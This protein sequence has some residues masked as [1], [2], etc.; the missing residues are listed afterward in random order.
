MFT[1]GNLARALGQPAPA[2]F[3]ELA[4]CYGQ[5]TRHYHNREH[6]ADCLAEFAT[7]RD[8]AQ[9]P[10]EVELAI[11]FHDAVYDSQ[12]SD[13]E[14]KSAEFAVARL[15]ALG[16][17]AVAWERIASIILAT[18]THAGL[19]AIDEKLMVDA[20]LAILAADSAK[21]AAYDAAIRREYAWVPEERYRPAR[22]AVLQNF[23]ARAYI[24]HT[25]SFRQRYEARA[26]KNLQASL[27]S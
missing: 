24:Y 26:R 14:A 10:N 5:P 7:V 15:R 4:A 21:F 13:N 16:I 1:A 9:Y 23:L 27:L 18:A 3:D 12:A 8:Q 6:I 11:W 20:D 2:L 25:G 22:V 17:E 19:S